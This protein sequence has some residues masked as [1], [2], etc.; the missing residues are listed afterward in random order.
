MMLKTAKALKMASPERAYSVVTR[1]RRALR[2]VRMLEGRIAEPEDW[3]IIHSKVDELEK[4][5]EA[6]GEEPA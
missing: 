5:L 1:A 3:K 4:A 6:F 2:A